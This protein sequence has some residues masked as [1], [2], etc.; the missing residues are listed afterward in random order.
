MRRSGFTMVELI[1]VIIIIGIL[2][3]AAIPKFGD[4]KD[5][6]KAATEYSALSS[7]SSAIEGAMEFQREDFNNVLI[8]WHGRGKDAS[9]VSG[10]YEIANT[11]GTVLD[12]ILKKNDDLQI[13]AFCATGTPGGA[14]NGAWDDVIFLKE[15]ASHKTLGTAEADTAANG[16]NGKPDK[17]D[18]WVFNASPDDVYIYHHDGKTDKNTTVSSGEIVLIDNGQATTLEV[19]A[20]NDAASEGDIGASLATAE[21]GSGRL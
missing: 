3:V 8:D 12:K 13:V 11:D 14:S 9:N 18:V 17:N 5:R 6:A 4:I 16:G 15:K 2:S 7:L 10:S 1:F 21:V 20:Q 19:T